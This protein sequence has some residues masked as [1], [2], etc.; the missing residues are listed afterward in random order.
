MPTKRKDLIAELEKS[1]WQLDRIRGSHHILKKG[2]RTV[3]I[4]CHNSD[5]PK[6]T[7]AALRKATGV[8]KK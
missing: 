4:P 1:G 7:E 8:Q 5:L 6:G 2:G 3:T